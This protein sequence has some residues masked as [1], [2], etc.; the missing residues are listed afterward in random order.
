MEIELMNYSGVRLSVDTI[1]E[2]E[3]YR[4]GLYRHAGDKVS[5]LRGCCSH[6]TGKDRVMLQDA[7]R[8]FVGGYLYRASLEG[9]TPFRGMYDD[10]ITANGCVFF[11]LVHNDPDA[12]NWYRLS[13]I[14]FFDTYDRAPVY[15]FTYSSVPYMLDKSGRLLDPNS[16]LNV[17]DR[18]C[19]S[20]SPGLLVI[21]GFDH[22]TTSVE[23]Y[24][25]DLARRHNLHIMFV[26]QVNQ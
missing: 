8:A 2:Q 13:F 7:T 6:L 14:D 4:G 26:N 3:T 20:L 23:S 22:F 19:S 15:P 12:C 11:D 17:C 9:F 10:M 25:L 21:D 18:A 5:F 1:P 24:F 16:F